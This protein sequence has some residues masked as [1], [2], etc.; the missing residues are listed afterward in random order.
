[1]ASDPVLARQLTAVRDELARSLDE[2]RELARGLHPAALEH[3]LAPA[4][5]SLALRSPVPASVSYKLAGRLS[6]PAELAAYFVA[7]EALTNVAKYAGA[8]H[9]EVRVARRGATA[10][11]EIADDGVGGAD[12]AAGS[13]LHGLA[14]RVE[15]LGGRLRV[16]SPPGAGTVVVAEL[17]CE[18]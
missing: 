13:G 6:R 1:M 16:A 12:P 7:S 14:D 5:D 10:V 2:L 3:G 18:S 17:P 9:A 15:A 8:S 11:I 4:L